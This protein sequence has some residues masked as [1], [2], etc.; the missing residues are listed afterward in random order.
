MQDCNACYCSA[1]AHLIRHPGDAPGAVKAAE[2]W[3][4]QGA[5]TEV[6]EWLADSA[7][8]GADSD[9]QKL[10]GFVKWGFTYAFRCVVTFHARD[11]MTDW[12]SGLRAAKLHVLSSCFLADLGSM[13][14]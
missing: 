2:T 7:Q 6:Q 3:A 8:P 11:C 1:I 5:V 4:S 10:I 9:C 14:M 13:C 12:F